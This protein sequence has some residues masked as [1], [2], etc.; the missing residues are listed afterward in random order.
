MVKEG[1][2]VLVQGENNLWSSVRVVAMDDDKLAVRSLVTGK[3]T[4][5]DRIKV[6]PVQ[7]TVNDIEGSLILI[8][9]FCILRATSVRSFIRVSVLANH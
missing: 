1:S 4:A 9:C 2:I 7:Q 6:F 3:E 5:V 8:V